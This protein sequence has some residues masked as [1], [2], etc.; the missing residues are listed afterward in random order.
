M[1]FENHFKKKIKGSHLLRITCA[2][3]RYF[4]ALY[5]KVGESNLV[6]MYLDR[7][8][9]SSMDLS[10]IPG[11]ILCP[12]CGVKIAT[13]YTVKTDNKPAYRLSPSMF[14]KAKVR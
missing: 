2:H 6:K 12:E 9:E 10:D 1:L 13:K 3:C 7:I 4:I 11:A 5:Q 8:V 14:H